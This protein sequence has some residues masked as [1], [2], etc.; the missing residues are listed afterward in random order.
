MAVPVYSTFLISTVPVP[1][2][3]RNGM[4]AGSTHVVLDVVGYFR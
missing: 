4:A 2:S 1:S 3:T